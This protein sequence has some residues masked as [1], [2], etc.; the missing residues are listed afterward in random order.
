MALGYREI[1]ILA[2]SVADLS[3]V[4]DFR[5][6]SATDGTYMDLNIG[7][8]QGLALIQGQIYNLDF[9]FSIFLLLEKHSYLC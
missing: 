1:S 6:D 9:G 5:K 4:K 2:F 8:S 3:P 7:E